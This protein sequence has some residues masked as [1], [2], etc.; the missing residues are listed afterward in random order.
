MSTEYLETQL[1]EGWFVRFKQGKR[2]KWRWMVY[3][4][5]SKFRAIASISGYS[6]REGAEADFAEL[7]E[8]I[9]RKN[10]LDMI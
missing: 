2:G 3:D 5:D 6:T 4:K 10:L 7:V 1:N 8:A 9:D